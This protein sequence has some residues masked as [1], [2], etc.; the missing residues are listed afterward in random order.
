MAVRQALLFSLVDSEA[1]IWAVNGQVR[2]ISV[3]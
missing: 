3:C 1:E 2:L